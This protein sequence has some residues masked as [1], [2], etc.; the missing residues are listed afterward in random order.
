MP[1]SNS[2]ASSSPQT[3]TTQPA[4]PRTAQR[5]SAAAAAP[6]PAPEST[7]TAEAISMRAYEKFLQRSPDEGSPE[8]DWLEAEQELLAEAHRH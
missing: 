6:K 1:H 3:T 7:V 5:P 2:H 4:A 8:E